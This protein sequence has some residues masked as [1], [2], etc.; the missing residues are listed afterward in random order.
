MN[1]EVYLRTLLANA[2]GY[3]NAGNMLFDHN[4]NVCTKYTEEHGTPI[5]I[6]EID[7][8]QVKYCST[9]DIVCLSL[10]LELYLKYVI[11]LN[12]H[13]LIG[14]RKL[15]EHSLIQLFSM[16]PDDAQKY[17]SSLCS[18]KL[19]QLNNFTTLLEQNSKSFTEWRY[20]HESAAENTALRF[21]V[22]LNQAMLNA[23]DLYLDE[24]QF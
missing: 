18:K 8:S 10:S 15:S 24:H 23:I 12:D 19:G 22:S 2:K 5:K 17:I 11:C 9:A 1:H 14:S 13:E 7:Y 3:K 4:Y 6:S 21:S 16:L 20:A